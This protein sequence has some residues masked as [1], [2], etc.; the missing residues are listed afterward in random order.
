MKY[1]ATFAALFVL[2]V[3]VT[4][5]ITVT[6]KKVVYERKSTEA[7]DFKKKFEVTYPV[8]EDVTD[9]A[10]K[11]RLEESVDYW[12]IFDTTLE[13]NLGDYYWLDS[14]WYEVG[15]N[16]NSLVVIKLFMEGSG[17]YP[18]GVVKTFVLDTTT[19]QRVAIQETFTGLPELVKKLSKM[20]EAEIAN[21][22]KQ[23]KEEEGD[24]DAADTIAQ[25]MEGKVIT[26]EYLE[27]FSVTDD[28]VIFHFDYG[29]PYAIRAFQP[30]GDYTFTWE[31]ISPHIKKDGILGRFRN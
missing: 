7:P 2:S 18:D 3:S 14:F 19:G 29:F 25:E 31:E 11:K 4:A 9:T 24:A 30:L 21:D 8:F 5:Q 17:A 26:V 6:P 1:F 15:Y 28:G 16:K 23:W 22:I 13:E 12:K 20:Q 10:V 27:E